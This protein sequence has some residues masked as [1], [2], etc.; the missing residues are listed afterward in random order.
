MPHQHQRSQLQSGGDH[1]HPNSGLDDP[2]YES[3][4]PGERVTV[5]YPPVC[6]YWQHSLPQSALAQKCG[7]LAVY[8]LA[9]AFVGSPAPQWWQCCYCWRPWGTWFTYSPQV[10]LFAPWW[11]V[12]SDPASFLPPI[13]RCRSETLESRQLLLERL[14]ASHTLLT[15]MYY[16]ACAATAGLTLWISQRPE[17]QWLDESAGRCVC[18]PRR[19]SM[20][21]RSHPAVWWC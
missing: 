16:G 3:Y 21:V 1:Y 14:T 10:G 19:A 17:W 20:A 12:S 11:M 4:A 6:G 15:C 2:W 13:H 7:I 5:T 9:A 8:T 18:A